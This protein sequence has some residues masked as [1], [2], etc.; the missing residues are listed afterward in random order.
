MKLTLGFGQ[1]SG[2]GVPPH[3][4]DSPDDIVGLR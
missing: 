1:G 2:W 3:G 4:T